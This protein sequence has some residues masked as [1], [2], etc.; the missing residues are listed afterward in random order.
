VINDSEFGESESDEGR[1]SVDDLDSKDY[2]GQSRQTY[3]EIRY[4][5]DKWE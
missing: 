4:L 1:D 3:Q 2:N 5:L